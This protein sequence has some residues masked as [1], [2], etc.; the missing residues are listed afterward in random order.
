MRYIIYGAG[1]IGGAIG[2]RLFLAGREVVLIARGA[3][4][5]AIRAGGL[6]LRTP[7]GDHRL[8][9]DVAGH[10][11]EIEFRDDDVVLLTMKTQD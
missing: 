5:D 10:P 2:G 3:H 7:E 4:L 8:P 11:R 1:G 9:I 6:L